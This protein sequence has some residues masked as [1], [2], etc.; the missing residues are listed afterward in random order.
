MNLFRARRILSLFLCYL[1][2]T[3]FAI[4]IV[5]PLYF[6]AISSL[7][8]GDAYTEN[9]LSIPVSPV[10]ENFSRA[11]GQMRMLR[12]MGNTLLS[13]GIAMVLYMFIC[14]AAGFAFGKLKFPGRLAVFT[15]VLFLQI[16]PQMVISGQVYQIASKMKLLNTY[17]GI[18]LIWVAYFAPFGT[19]IMTTYYANVPKELIESARIDGAN[20]FQ[21]LFR[22]MMPVA[23]P[24]L[25]TIGIIGSL[26]MWNELP[27]AMLI[28]QKT[29][30]RTMTLGIALMQGEYGL[31]VPR[32]SAAVLISASI[33]LVLYLIFQNYV[34][35]GATAGSVK[36]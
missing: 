33:P 25:G 18:I 6:S 36:G 11:L 26:A 15:L 27:F 1:V 3:L 19:Y 4:V 20:V 21:Q 28:L 17:P 5:Y 31:P 2:L 10:L 23:R 34:T 22:I 35:M 9:K 8:T 7:K 30:L 29:H 12:Y 16:F 32:L 24:M 14:S 13:V